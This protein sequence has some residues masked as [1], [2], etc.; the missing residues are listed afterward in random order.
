[1][2]F[3]KLPTACTHERFIAVGGKV[4]DL[5]DLRIPHLNVDQ[6]GYVPSIPG[7]GGGDYLRLNLCLDCG[8]AIGF[9]PLTD[10]EL[11]AALG[12]DED[13]DD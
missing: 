1:M 13:G 7:I 9:K 3:P 12:D 8:T 2:T 11:R 4:S 10:Q 6:D 5:C